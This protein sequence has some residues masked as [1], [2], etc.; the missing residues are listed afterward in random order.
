MIFVFDKVYAKILNSKFS[1]VSFRFRY[2]QS[3]NFKIL[4]SKLESKFSKFWNQNQNRNRRAF[5]FKF[6]KLWIQ[7]PHCFV[8]PIANYHKAKIQSHDSAFPYWK[9][10]RCSGTQGHDSTPSVSPLV[11]RSLPHS[12]SISTLLLLSLLPFSSSL[13]KHPFHLQYKLI[14]SLSLSDYFSNLKL[15]Y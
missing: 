2:H 9:S 13:S 14:L 10:F 5:D 4:K 7:K 11:P 8:K 15:L 1:Y 3:W 12:L 6:Q